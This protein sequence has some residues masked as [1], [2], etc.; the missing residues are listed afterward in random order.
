MHCN[1]HCQL[2]KQFRE[3]EKDQPH[4]EKVTA[5]KESFPFLCPFIQKQKND[6][7]ENNTTLTTY[8][9]C[10]KPRI[11]FKEVFHPPKT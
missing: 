9:E 6:I 8:F 1:G 7:V 5:E 10:L 11:R 4:K 2:E 3:H